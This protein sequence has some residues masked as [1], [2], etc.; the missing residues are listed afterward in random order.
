MRRAQVLLTER[1]H[2]A[3][4]QLSKA[5][6]R[7]RSEIVREAL[8]K[9]LPTSGVSPHWKDGIK[10]AFGMWKDRLEVEQERREARK[11]L[12]EIRSPI[13]IAHLTSKNESALQ[14]QCR[15]RLSA[16][17]G[18]RSRSFSIP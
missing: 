6:N 12:I 17:Q 9:H 13:V 16:W 8:D 10:A 18:T 3:L 5:T 7:P 2:E 15:G 14:Q 4:K 1:Q 11:S